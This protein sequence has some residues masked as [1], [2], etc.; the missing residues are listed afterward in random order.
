VY[1]VEDG[2]IVAFRNYGDFLTMLV[3]LGVLPS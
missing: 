1:T 3:Q 2:K